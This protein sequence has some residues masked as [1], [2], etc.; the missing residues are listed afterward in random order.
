MKAGK[1]TNIRFEIIHNARQ[2]DWIWKLCIVLIIAIGIAGNSYVFYCCTHMPA[3][4]PEELMLQTD[5]E[6]EEL[7]D[8]SRGLL[9]DG[10]YSDAKNAASE[11]TNS[12]Y[13]NIRRSLIIM[14][15]LRDQRENG[16]DMSLDTQHY[17]VARM[18]FAREDALYGQAEELRNEINRE[19]NIRESVKSEIKATEDREHIEDLRVRLPY[20]GMR[21]S[22]LLLT[23]LGP[24]NYIMEYEYDDSEGWK[25]RTYDR[26]YKWVTEG[27]DGEAAAAV[28]TLEGKITRVD[29]T[30]SNE[31]WD[32]DDMSEFRS[33]VQARYKTGTPDW[34][35]EQQVGADYADAHMQEYIDMITEGIDDPGSEYYGCDPARLENTAW[36]LALEHWKE[37]QRCVFTDT[38]KEKEMS[39][40]EFLDDY[41]DPYEEEKYYEYQD[42]PGDDSL[43][44]NNRRYKT[45]AED[46]DSSENTETG[47][48]VK[49][50]ERKH[51]L[52]EWEKHEAKRD[53]DVDNFKTAEEYA[54]YYYDDFLEDLLL[55]EDPDE[56]IDD[57]YVL[58]QAYLDAMDWWEINQPWPKP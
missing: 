9:L 22:E 26:I 8:R 16:G 11:I 45:N 46:T 30:E 38:F 48:D 14:S 13:E 37:G 4:D 55:E 43:I 44:T 25:N 35:I 20:E 3:E 29:I 41:Y 52:A 51:T 1:N 17:K 7:V 15:K 49:N 18:S 2:E 53:H 23:G 32:P 56:P 47:T 19:F 40:N 42:E 6:A 54:D 12:K 27:D 39:Y 34:A 24:Y 21:P 31:Y 57:Y 36:M 33:R 28:Y 58:D 50:K 10:R 5:A